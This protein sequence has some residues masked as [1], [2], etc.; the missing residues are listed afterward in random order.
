M[1][2]SAASPSIDFDWKMR[3][4]TPHSTALPSIMGI[5]RLCWIGHSLPISRHSL[6]SVESKKG[7]RI[8][9][10]LHESSSWTCVIG[11]TTSREVSWCSPAPPH[12]TFLSPLAINNTRLVPQQ[13]LSS[14]SNV[15]DIESFILWQEQRT[16]KSYL[17]VIDLPTSERGQIMQE[18]AMMGITAGSLFPGLD[19]ACEQFRERQFNL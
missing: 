16:G 15:D 9:I 12:V 1:V 4:I 13:A 5:L 8:L 18:L 2:I 11:I 6:R 17:K 14:V 10:V 3:S 19:G 7:I